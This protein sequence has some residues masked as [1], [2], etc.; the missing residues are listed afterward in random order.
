MVGFTGID[1][2]ERTTDRLSADLMGGAGAAHLRSAARDWGRLSSAYATAAVDLDRALHRLAG[3]ARLGHFAEP[4]APGIVRGRQRVSGRGMT[5]GSGAGDERGGPL[6]QYARWLARHAADLA[7]CARRAERQA[8]AYEAAVRAMPG[9]AELTALRAARV[10]VEATPLGDGGVLI[11]AI[12]RVERDEQDA[13]RRAAAA[14]VDYEHASSGLAHAWGLH[15]PPHARSATD[16]S[17]TRGEGR[18][19]AAGTAGRGGSGIGSYGGG[20]GFGPAPLPGYA[21]AAL[22]REEPARRVAATAPAVPAGTPMGRGMPLVPA[23]LGAGAAASRAV[24]RP[25]GATPSD[26]GEPEA[27]TVH[28]APDVVGGEGYGSTN[29]APDLVSDGGS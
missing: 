29:G 14:M 23:M 26:P 9:A 11:G 22:R 3:V 19:V 27:F 25:A 1:W 6:H 2:D 24:T 8:D 13:H 10:A 7:E 18:S 15:A 12:G 16:R 17:R 4:A 20:T 28:T 5:A 21:A